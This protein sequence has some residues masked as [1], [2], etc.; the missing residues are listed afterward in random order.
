MRTVRE[1]YVVES[2]DDVGRLLAA[3][4]D[5]DRGALDECL[6]LIYHELRRIAAGYL[7]A[8]RQSH[9]LQPTALVHEAY[10]R[11]V[12]Q[13]RVDWQGRT[14]FLGVAAMAMRRILV[15][16]ARRH[17]RVKRGGRFQQ[18][19]LSDVAADS[20]AFDVDIIALH[21]VLERLAASD[22]RQARIVELR[23]FAGL[24][25][26]EI[27][28]TTGLS[29]RTVEREWTHA[30]AWMRRELGGERA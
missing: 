17:G 10:M 28:G 7:R 27:A 2:S 30:R 15:D 26:A 4:A 8:E 23:C 16:H 29:E 21:D 19:T 25:V 18:V 11:L 12:D 14:H 24:T 13:S 6:P 3:Y 9:T 1:R 5:G 20:G 22:E